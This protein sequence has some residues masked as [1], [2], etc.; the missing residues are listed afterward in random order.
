MS[1]WHLGNNSGGVPAFWAA[2]SQNVKAH[3]LTAITFQISTKQP[4]FG[5]GIL[6]PGSNLSAEPD[7][8]LD[9]WELPH[10][11]S[12]SSFFARY[13]QPSPPPDNFL[14]AC[15]ALATYTKIKW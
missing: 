8:A 6:R 14:K 2:L 12:K 13:C 11:G 5:L 10:Q 9:S 15:Q 1:T 7:T 4:V 3:R